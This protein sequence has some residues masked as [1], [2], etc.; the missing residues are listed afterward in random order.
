MRPYDRDEDPIEFGRV[1]AL[2]DAV[3]AIALT[4]LVLDLALP[5][6]A[7][8]APLA[9]ALIDTIP[10]FYAFV[11]SVAVVGTFF[12]S[13]HELLS[14]LQRIDTGF[15]GLTIPYLGLIALIPFAQSVLSDRADEPLAFALYGVVLGLASTV[16]ALMLGHAR[17]RGL[18]REPLVGRDAWFEVARSGLPIVLF[19]ASAGLAFLVGEWAV[20]FWVAIWPLDSMLVRLQRRGA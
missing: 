14:R 11:I 2:T 9:E 8:G 10:R 1:V 4:L 16:G 17:R 3:F 18:L 15:L 13:H 20:L 19:L 12:L 7:A 5:A 6:Q